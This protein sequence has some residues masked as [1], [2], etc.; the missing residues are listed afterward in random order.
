MSKDFVFV[1]FPS[2]GHLQNPTLMNHLSF[3]HYCASAFSEVI[4]LH[5]VFKECSQVLFLCLQPTVS[6]IFFFLFPETHCLFYFL[7]TYLPIPI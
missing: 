2:I 1:F 4:D 7:T 5:S 6:F 3:I